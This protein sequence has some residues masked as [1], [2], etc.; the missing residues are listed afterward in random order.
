MRNILVKFKFLPMFLYCYTKNLYIPER[1]KIQNLNKPKI[2]IFWHRLLEA[3]QNFNGKMTCS[4][5]KNT[6]IGLIVAFIVLYCYLSDTFNVVL[7]DGP[8]S[9]F[10]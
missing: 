3:L 2:C 9:K 8:Q 5:L 7:L 4:T 1:F 10:A 6:K